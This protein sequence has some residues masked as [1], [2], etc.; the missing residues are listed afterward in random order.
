MSDDLP[1]HATITAITSFKDLSTHLLYVSLSPV[2]GLGTC[3]QHMLISSSEIPA[4]NLPQSPSQVRVLRDPGWD[5]LKR[6]V[7]EE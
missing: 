3:R 5:S 7:R 4:D 6:W 2:P 1:D